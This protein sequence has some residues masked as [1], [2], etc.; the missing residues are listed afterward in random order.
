MSATDTVK[1]LQDALE[2]FRPHTKGPVRRGFDKPRW[3][4]S[5]LHTIILTGLKSV[6]EKAL[7]VP[8]EKH[9]AFV[10]YCLQWVGYI[11]NHH[12]IEE[13]LYFTHFP[14]SFT[15]TQTIFSEHQTFH[16]KIEEMKTYLTNCLPIGTKW[17][18]RDTVEESA[19]RTQKEPVAFDGARLK[20]IIDTFIVPLT[21]HLQ[22]EITY[23]DPENIKAS[24][25]T[26]KQLEEMDKAVM[27]HIRSL[28]P[29]PLLMYTVYHLP[30]DVEFPP[31]PKFVKRILVPWI[32]HWKGSQ[33]WQ[34]CP[35][36][37]E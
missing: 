28:G 1:V 32:F 19:S 26:E 35:K 18:L 34:F 24:G 4:M 25:M 23:L 3:E 20:A 5:N 29:H 11:I 2:V 27:A 8:E 17:G 22:A 14:E 33:W 6:Y 13:N 9:R 37:F 16:A 15:Q 21:T 36:R 12:W 10:G 7:T 31:A 30:K